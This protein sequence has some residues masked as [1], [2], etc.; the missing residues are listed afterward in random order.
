MWNR[1]GNGN[2]G[3]PRSMVRHH[4]AHMRRWMWLWLAIGCG[5]P[6]ADP[7]DAS[8][9]DAKTDGG[10][11]DA[12]A[13]GDA[14]ASICGTPCPTFVPTAPHAV[15]KAGTCTLAQIDDFY[16]SCMAPLQND[17]GD[18]GGCAAFASANATCAGCL[19]TDEDAGTWGALAKQGGGMLYRP[20]VPGCL[21]KT[22]T[23]PTCE[24]RAWDAWACAEWYCDEVCQ[25]PII[26][27]DSVSLAAHLK[28]LQ[29]AHNTFCRPQAKAECVPADAGPTVACAGDT[30]ET[31]FRNVAK[32]LCGPKLN[33]AGAD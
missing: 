4:A 10:A 30:F 6:N 8:L 5:T 20:N 1:N 2:G 33:D 22:S 26:Q 15:P 29:D 9:G 19:V 28:C 21:G 12:K 32:V 3:A 27:G 7:V 16:E 23:D 14:C 13:D 18:D 25:W 24:Q 11:T 17:G 31:T